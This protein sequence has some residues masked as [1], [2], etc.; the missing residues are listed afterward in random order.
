M[1][2]ILSL[3]DDSNENIEAN[4]WLQVIFLRL[5]W[6]FIEFLKLLKDHCLDFH[7]YKPKVSTLKIRMFFFQDY[8]FN[9]SNGMQMRQCLSIHM[10]EFRLVWFSAISICFL[11]VCWLILAGLVR[12]RNLKDC[13]WIP[14]WIRLLI[15]VRERFS[16][17]LEGFQPLNN[18]STHSTIDVLTFDSGWSQ[19]LEGALNRIRGLSP[20]GPVLWN[21]YTVCWLP[22]SPPPIKI[23]D[24]IGGRLTDLI[25]SCYL[26]LWF[27]SSL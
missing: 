6:G 12:Q 21:L 9:A 11:S 14:D 16:E 25:M 17:T 7:I 1:L 8:S 27:P 18:N 22:D 4:D 23:G 13:K 5:V 3:D 10:K 15:N 2:H 20:T 24:K 26:L 19:R